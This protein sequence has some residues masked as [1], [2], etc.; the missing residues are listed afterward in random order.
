[1]KKRL[2]GLF[3]SWHPKNRITK[4]DGNA[5]H[6]IGT[7]G[8]ELWATG[9]WGETGQGKNGEPLPIKGYWAMIYVREADNWKIR[10][11]AWNTTPD[12]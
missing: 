12:S 6:L 10:L 4:L 11:K 3:H 5:L 9:E 7:A 2:V 8:N 1:M